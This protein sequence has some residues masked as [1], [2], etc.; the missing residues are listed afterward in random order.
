M[1][2]LD[3]RS[4]SFSPL[5]TS[6]VTMIALKWNV[7]T[8]IVRHIDVWISYFLR[9]SVRNSSPG[10]CMKP[11]EMNNLRLVRFAIL[12]IVLLGSS[13]QGYN[14][15]DQVFEGNSEGL[16]AA[17]GD[18]NSDKLTDTFII[19]QDRKSFSILLSHSKPPYLRNTT[20]NCTFNQEKIASLV[21]GDFDGDAAMDVVVIVESNS[22]IYL[23]VHIAWGNLSALECP[24]APLFKMFGHPLMLD[25]NSDMISD[26]FGLDEFQLRSFWIFG[27]NRTVQSKVLMNSSLPLR[28]PHSHS[29]VDLDGDMAAD[30]LLTGQ[31]SFEF[32]RYTASGFELNRTIDLPVKD[33]HFM[34][35]SVFVD[36]NFNGY[37]EHLVPVCVDKHCRNSSLYLYSAADERW[38]SIE[39]DL[40]EWSFVRPYPTGD[41][42]YAETITARAGDVNLDGYPDLLMTLTHGGKKRAVLLENLPS[43]AKTYSRKFVAKWS[44]LSQWND[45]LM[46]TFYDIQQKGVLDVL[47]VQQ[48][49]VNGQ[50][51]MIMSAYKND[52]DYDANFIKV[53]V[54]TGRCYGN[55]TYGQIPYGTNLPGPFIGYRTVNSGGQPQEACSTQLFQSAYHS[56]QLPYS[57]F[58]LGHTPN[59]VETLRVGVA[60]PD[61]SA[62]QRRSREWTQ[63]IPNSQMIIIPNLEGEPSHWLN[64]LFVTP[65]RAVA[66]SAG[67]LIGFGAFLAILVVVL[68]IRERRDDKREQAAIAYRFHFDAM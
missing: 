67:A 33:A 4:V 68:H 34:G 16:I 55:C 22:P 18:F 8:P 15:T 42:I 13:A 12:S 64:K 58:G 23:D 24:T 17:F 45:T 11:A 10:G 62:P 53:L 1:N 49:R 25:Y 57:L 52:L 44:V 6:F 50:L 60:F 66:L 37:L 5:L 54:L 30:L 27:S 46:A 7:A 2:R 36:V 39:C 48:Q 14:F 28:N 51:Q 43:S 61:D 21:P 41:N 47:M 9:L 29:F 31:D 40:N 35:Q 65:S 63:V 3:Q 20:L 19:S 59:F 56:L 38:L 32:W 26:L